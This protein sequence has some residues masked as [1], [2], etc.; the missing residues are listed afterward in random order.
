MPP[1]ALRPATPAGLTGPSAS[2]DGR[3]LQERLRLFSGIAFLI[4]AVF[5]GVGRVLAWARS[6][7]P[8]DPRRAGRAPRHP[9]SH[10]RDVALLPGRGEAG[11]EPSARSTFC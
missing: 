9:R 8:A 6:G 5:N 7:E 11:E 2:A 4:S 1:D 10:G 3:L